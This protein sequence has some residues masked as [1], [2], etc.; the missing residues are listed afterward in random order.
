MKTS[1]SPYIKEKV[2]QSTSA[3]VILKEITRLSIPIMFMFFLQLAYQLTDLFWAGRLG[4]DSVAGIS[5]SLP[6]LMFVTALGGGIATAGTILVAQYKGQNNQK[7]INKISAQVL[8]LAGVFALVVS[9]VGFFAAPE[10]IRLMKTEENVLF[11]ALAYIK[12][13]FTG[14]F[15]LF[16]FSVFQ[17]LMKGTG[18]VKLPLYISLVTVVL[19][20]VLDPLLIFGYGIIPTFGISGTA[21]ATTIAY[22]ISSIVGITVLLKGKKGI[23]LNINE[24]KPDLPTI[25]KTFMLGYPASIENSAGQLK[26]VILIYL[27]TLFGTSSIAGYGTGVRII[28]FLSIPVFGLSMSA[29]ILVG[30]YLGAG[31]ITDVHRTVKL[32]ALTGFLLLSTIGLLIF[33]LAEQMIALFIPNKPEAIRIGADF[34]K[35]ASVAVGL[36]GIEHILLGSF[37]GAGNTFLVMSLSIFLLSAAMLPTAYIL[38]R[39]TG[40]GVDGIWLAFPITNFAAVIIT[41]F[42]Y[43]RG[44]KKNKIIDS[45]Y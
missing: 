14:T 22:I 23:K 26:M 39:H 29:T 35:I 37:R 9:L 1:F 12:I 34:L 19:N 7:E 16:C 38:S 43:K 3:K 13:S 45:N 25:K 15:F 44:I 31:K 27:V 18:E 33:L 40:L 28:T 4:V 21:L 24:L 5:L 41:M 42:L 10:L 36:G 17:A 11:E 8:L 30:Q 2:V 20:F 32:A 6:I